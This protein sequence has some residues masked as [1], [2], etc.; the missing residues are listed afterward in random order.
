MRG[1]E[2]SR[3]CFSPASGTVRVSRYLRRQLFIDRKLQIRA[4]NSRRKKSCRVRGATGR[5]NLVTAVSPLFTQST[6][7]LWTPLTAGGGWGRAGDG[8]GRGR[9]GNTGGGC[10][11][12]GET[13]TFASTH[14]SVED[15][16]RVEIGSGWWA[17]Q[18]LIAL[19]QIEEKK[20]KRVF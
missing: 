17:S 8:E 18:G 5:C 12:R 7:L 1:Y 13:I 4:D 10:E 15:K 2:T 19:S 14:I 16:G 11:K 6:I 9:G 3:E 20:L